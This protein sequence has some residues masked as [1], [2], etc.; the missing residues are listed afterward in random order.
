MSDMNRQVSPYDKESLMTNVRRPALALLAPLVALLSLGVV[1]PQSADAGTYSVHECTAS[2]GSFADAAVEGAPT[3]YTAN[4]ACEQAGANYLQIGTSGQVSAGQSKSWA[5][6]A[7]AGTQINRATGDFLLQGRADHGGHRAFFFHRE[8]GQGGDQLDS[9]QGAGNAAGGFDSNQFADAPLRRVGIGLDCNSGV[10]CP[11]KSGIY[12]RIGNLGFEMEDTVAPGAPELSG[13]AL[14]GWINGSKLLNVEASDVGAG[15]Y[16]GV[17]LV[18]QAA[19]DLNVYCSPVTD[20]SG[21]AIQMKPCP[22]TGT[23]SAVLNTASYPFVEGANSLE[24]CAYDYGGSDRGSGCKSVT[25]TVDTVA[26]TAPTGLVVAGGE[27]WK[28]DNEFDLDWNNPPQAHAPI[29][30]AEVRLTG[31]GNYDQTTYYPGSDRTSIDNV[32]V[33]AK[34]DYTARVFLRDA[35]GNETPANASSVHLRFDDTVP[36]PK[37]PDIANGWISRDELAAGYTQGW[38]LTTPAETPISGISGYRVVVNTNSDTDPCSGAADPRACSQPLTEVG[39]DSRSRTLRPGDLVEGANYVH[40]VP[41]SGSGMR[42]TIAKHAAV[43]ADFTDPTTQ[44]SG[45]AVGEWLNR[46]ADLSVT[47]ADALSGMQDTTEFPGDD[48]PATFLRIDGQTQVANARQLNQTLATEGSHEV[49]YWARDLA[50]NTGAPQTTT[51]KIDKTAPTVAFTNTQDPEDPDKLVA[52]VSD[53][54]SG[55]VEGSISYR[56]ADGNQWKRLD[57]VVRDGSLTARVD[58]GDLKF[59]LTY[60]FRAEARDLAGN[61]AATTSKQNGDPMRVTGPFRTITSLADLKINGKAKAR[62]KYGRKLRVTGEL[63]GEGGEGVAN[64]S[65]DLVSSYLGGSKKTTDV[66]SVITDG[67]GVFNAMLPKGPS[68]E[69]AAEYRGGLRFLGTRSASVRANVKSKVTLKVPPVVDSD[70]GIAFTGAVMARGAKFG[71]K[72]KRL[73]VQVLVGRKWKTVGR[74]F[75]ASRNGKFRLSYE[76]T[77][78]YSRPVDFTFRAVVTKERGFPFLPSKSKARAVTV[79]P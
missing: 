63:I 47:A 74:S 18:N 39:I 65:V 30:G 66:V 50:G 25:L 64:A 40:V 31:P 79:T 29:V 21:A 27:G 32:A 77:Q 71:K 69:V 54:L 12:A 76:F 15:L 37:S 23:R 48:P 43:K 6:T 11:T 26:P 10:T 52:P 5:F 34:G 51:I 7:P 73:E 58:S 78:S 61:V 68:R 41:V 9:H 14:S 4:N 3:G 42:A 33:P 1:M 44:L 22:S 49:S 8:I 55:V 72:G 36:Q 59:D 35:A 67:R 62:V 75:R 24:A 57:T 70:E 16:T 45:L 53:A 56:Q 38:A 17:V 13:P 20:S 19:V 28:R 60:E 46:D 2:Q